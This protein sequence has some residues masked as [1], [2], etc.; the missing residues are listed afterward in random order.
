M[1]EQE[2][3]KAQK[4]QRSRNNTSQYPI[5][6]KKPNKPKPNKVKTQDN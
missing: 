2:R 6:K 3:G 5:V 4:P 1:V